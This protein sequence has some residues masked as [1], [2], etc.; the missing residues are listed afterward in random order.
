[1]AVLTVPASNPKTGLFDRIG[2]FVHQAESSVVLCCV[3]IIVASV[4]WGVL[5]RYISQKPAAWTG[6]VASIAFCWVGFI[7]AAFIYNGNIHP[8][9][10]DSNTIANVLP[11]RVLGFTS[12]ALQ[13]VVL[14]AVG[15]LAFK[16]IGINVTNPTAVLR[17]P[18]SIYYLPIAWFSVSSLV[19]LL[20]RR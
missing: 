12:L 16:Q 1:M 7:G 4:M 18:G 19:R 3:V 11:R 6:E 9:I 20:C 17:L 10:F 13:L 8:R 2:R 14:I 15:A 5:T